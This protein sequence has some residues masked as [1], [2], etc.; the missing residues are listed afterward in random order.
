MNIT[1]SAFVTQDS[2]LS[3]TSLQ[4]Y[5]SASYDELASKFGKPLGT[6][7]KSSAAWVLR[8]GDTLIT[9]YDSVDQGFENMP[10]N[11]AKLRQWHIGGVKPSVVGLVAALL[12]KNITGTS[13]RPL[14]EA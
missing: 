12:E 14:V 9:I 8:I 5:L 6:F 4:G 11:G 2:H 1:L 7:E 10:P 3:G 13:G